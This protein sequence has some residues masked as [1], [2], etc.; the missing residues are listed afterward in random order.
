[1]QFPASNASIVIFQA[2]ASFSAALAQTTPQ[3]PYPTRSFAP[4]HSDLPRSAGDVPCGTERS[5][6]RLGA[7][8]GHGICTR[9]GI[10]RPADLEGSDERQDAD[11]HTRLHGFWGRKR[12]GS[13]LKMPKSTL[14]LSSICVYISLAAPRPTSHQEPKVARR[15]LHPK[16]DKANEHATRSDLS[17]IAEVGDG[18]AAGELRVYVA[19]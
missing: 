3:A 7:D 2:V 11:F 9:Q 10:E 16:G 8:A 18:S 5:L 13:G 15:P 4:V 1:M 19:A 17:R 6:R 14:C 12:N